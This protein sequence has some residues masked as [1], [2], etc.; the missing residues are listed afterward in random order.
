[1]DLPQGDR[2]TGKIGV[3][4]NLLPI[5]KAA[6]HFM[7]RK[8]DPQ[9]LIDAEKDMLPERMEPNSKSFEKYFIE[10]KSYAQNHQNEQILLVIFGAS[11]GYSK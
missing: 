8:L 2:R 5:Q 11:H 4:E 9:V 10:L 3:E 1:M 6:Y 7:S